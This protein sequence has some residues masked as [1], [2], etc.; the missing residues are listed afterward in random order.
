MGFF[1]DE[2]WYDEEIRRQSDREYKEKS[3]RKSVISF[4]EV[5]EEKLAENDSKGGWDTCTVDFLL[6]K[7]QEEYAEVIEAVRSGSTIK[8]VSRECADLANICMMLSEQYKKLK[9]AE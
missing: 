2:S 9:G 5:M 7:L 4:S 3:L 6:L 1:G 8:D